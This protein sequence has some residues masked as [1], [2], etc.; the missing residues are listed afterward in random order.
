[1]LHPAGGTVQYIR[2]GRH[3]AFVLHAHLVFVTKCRHKVFT[4]AHLK[5]TEEITRAVCAD[6]ECEL[7]EFNGENSHVHLLVNFPP[8]IALSKL[9][10]SLKGVSSRRLRQEYPEL[11]RHYWRAQRLWSGSYFAGSVDGAPLSI[12]RQYIEQQNRPL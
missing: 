8:E 9:V 10:N 5:R 4:D 12:V 6:F 7:A 3:C 1:M 2:T 11:V